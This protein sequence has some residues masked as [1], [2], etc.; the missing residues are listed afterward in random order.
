MGH[1]L[2]KIYTRTGDDGTTGLGSGDRVRQG[3]CQRV[4]AYGSVDELNSVVGMVLAVDGVPDDRSRHVSTEIQHDLFD[5]GGELCTPGIVSHRRTDSSSRLEQRT[6]RDS[7]LT[8]RPSRNSSLP[9]GRSCRSRLPPR[10][11]HVSAGGRSGECGPLLRSEDV[12]AAGAAIPE[13]ISRT[14][15]S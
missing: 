12:G 3:R 9:G 1:R 7:T 13:S 10:P 11:C 15:C 5:L 4:E 14:C 2:S 8:S 6:R